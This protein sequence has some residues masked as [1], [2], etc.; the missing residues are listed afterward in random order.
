MT[1]WLE[2]LLLAIAAALVADLSFHAAWSKGHEAWKRWLTLALGW[3]LLTAIGGPSTISRFEDARHPKEPITRADLVAATTIP[4]RVVVTQTL[5]FAPTKTDDLRINVYF[6][7]QGLQPIASPTIHFSVAT[8]TGKLAASIEDEIFSHLSAFTS[9][10]IN[11]TDLM[12]VGDTRFSTLPSQ[13]DQHTG[14]THDKLMEIMNH[15]G[16]FY[17]AVIIRFRVPK[18][19]ALWETEQCEYWD[20]NIP[21]RYYNLI[22]PHMCSGHNGIFRVVS[23]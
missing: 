18:S 8:A 4:P 16:T 14:I 1:W 21:R 6:S 11:S 12:Q 2:G 3:G 15:H 9:P 23:K 7:N 17:L 19:N 20:Y 5:V 13:L 22:A 10:P